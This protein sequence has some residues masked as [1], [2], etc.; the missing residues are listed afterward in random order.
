M[1]NNLLYCLVVVLLGFINQDAHAA[2][3]RGKKIPQKQTVAQPAQI[4]TPTIEKI[5]IFKT[6]DNLKIDFIYLVVLI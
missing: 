3:I 2:P 5:I 1:K 6:T 4:A